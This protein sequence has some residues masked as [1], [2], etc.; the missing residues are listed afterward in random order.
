MLQH[1]PIVQEQ[2]DANH[3]ANVDRWIRGWI[4]N[5]NLGNRA[6]LFP[7]P[8]S[9]YDPGFSMFLVMESN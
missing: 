2:Q 4:L 8:V 7:I 1:P 6:A 3:G 9:L 5:E